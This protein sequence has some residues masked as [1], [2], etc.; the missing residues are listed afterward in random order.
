MATLHIYVV[1]D[2]IKQKQ[3]KAI[4]KNLCLFSIELL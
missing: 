3:N 1:L 4:D 2:S